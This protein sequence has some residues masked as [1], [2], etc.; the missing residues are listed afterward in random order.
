MKYLVVLRGIPGS[1]KSAFIERMGL[2]N[3]TLSSDEYRLRLSSY[4]R[5]ITG[6]PIINQEHNAVVWQNLYA[7][8]EYRMRQGEFTIIDATH[9]TKKSFEKYR[10][11]CKKYFYRSC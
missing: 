4:R 10:A 9:T 5:D 3:Y 8:L 7:D 11:L 2:K 1:G 6:I